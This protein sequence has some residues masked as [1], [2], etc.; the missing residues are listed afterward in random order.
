MTEVI[1][2]AAVAAV[3]AGELVLRETRP[4]RQPEAL[5]AMGWTPFR[6]GLLS[7]AVGLSAAVGVFTLLAALGGVGAAVVGGLAGLVWLPRFYLFLF[8]R[9]VAA[10][11]QPARDGALLSWLRRV[12]LYVGAG[13]PIGAAVLSAAERVPGRA[14][15]PIRTAIS[16][17]LTQSRDPLLAVSERLEG[18]A[19]EP[20]VATLAGAERSGAAS[21]ALL[22]QILDRS[23]RVLSSRKIE[24]IERLARSVA[25]VSTI[26][27]LVTTGL[28]MMAV[29]FTVIY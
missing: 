3:G 19:V 13:L 6:L 16:Q 9:G 23:V 10:S 29:I 21:I 8:C 17:A 2:A 28:L 25:L 1:A 18:S 24:R 15:G 22:D 11:F 7:V 20:L 5:A 12:R 14:F 26:V 4:L 27:T